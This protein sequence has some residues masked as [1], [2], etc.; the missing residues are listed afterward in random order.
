MHRSGKRGHSRRNH[1][2]SPT[3]TSGDDVGCLLIALALAWFFGFVSFHSRD[4]G[5]AIDRIKDI[6]VEL[7]KA[8]AQ[9]RQLT[10]VVEEIKSDSAV[11]ASRRSA[12][13]EQV[14]QLEETRDQIALNLEAASKLVRP[15]GKSR[16]QAFLDTIF[17]GALGDLLSK[18]IL[19]LVGL[20]VGKRAWRVLRVRLGQRE[21][22]P[23]PPAN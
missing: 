13:E 7:T 3:P 2:A 20:F 23:T 17:T 8:E 10:R 6:R 14:T 19:A 5:E 21:G 12:L 15:S 18:A 4:T 1:Q 16:W 22:K 11:L 9:L